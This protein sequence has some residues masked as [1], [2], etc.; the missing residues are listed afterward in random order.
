MGTQNNFFVSPLWVTATNFKNP[1]SQGS[2]SAV[3]KYLINCRIARIG[4]LDRL[5]YSKLMGKGKTIDHESSNHF[6]DIK[7]EPIHL[8]FLKIFCPDYEY[9]L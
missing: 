2:R 4:Y 8:E 7:D 3:S 6:E 9:H 1:Q 5:T